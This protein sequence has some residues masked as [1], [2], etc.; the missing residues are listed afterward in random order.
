MRHRVQLTAVVVVLAA[1]VGWALPAAA[2]SDYQSIPLPGWRMDGQTYAVA[3]AGNVVY[4]G[5]AFT[6]VTAPDGT[7]TPRRNLA[8]FDRTTGALLPGFRADTNGTIRALVTDGATLWVGGSY[9]SIGAVTRA[10]LAALDAATGAP[11]AGFRSDASAIVYGLDLRAGRLFVGGSFTTLNGQPRRYAASVD[12]AT[13]AVEAFAPAPDN[14]VYAIR[15]DD[16][17]ARVYLGGIFANVA[18][19]PRLGLSAVD[20]ATGALTGPA[21][22]DTYSVNFGLAL[23]ETGSRLFVAVGGTGNQAAAFSTTTGARL[24]RHRAEGDVQAI[25]YANGTVYFGFHEGFEG[26][27]TVRLL[28]ADGATGVLD[29]TFRPTFDRFWGIRAL[30]ATPDGLYGGGDFALVGGVTVAGLVR[31]PVRTGPR[32]TP[33]SYLGTGAMWRYR[34]TGSAPATGWASPGAD[35]STWP[36]GASQLGFGDGDE[37]TV[38][39]SGSPRRFPTSYF[40]TTFLVGQQPSSLTLSLLADDGA[41][42]YVNGVEIARDNL[43]AGTLAY[44][45]LASSN[46]SGSAE[47][48]Y[49]TFTIDP[50]ALVVGTNT[51][52]VEVHQDWLGSSDLSLDLRLT[53]LVPV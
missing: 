21:F 52:A 30:T 45:T 7:V 24:W 25:A 37:A 17:G 1:L 22:T 8:A 48:A 32:T 47:S 35:D 34:A 23:D 27:F 31:F 44:A 14:S 36:Q 46:R 18:G 40:R 11:R 13:G 6:Q 9:S 16:T 4:V 3:T 49:R 20:G 41:A 19:V 43:P 33:I 50:A 15:A 51:I 5:G 2:D 38:I 29:S 53:G 42:V 12:P 28:A 10:R 39:P 26:D